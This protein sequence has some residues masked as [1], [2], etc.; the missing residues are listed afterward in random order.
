MSPND[1]YL[2]AFENP[3]R[4]R[5]TLDIRET[6]IHIETFDLSEIDNLREDILRQNKT[7]PF[8]ISADE[9]Y[10]ALAYPLTLMSNDQMATQFSQEGLGLKTYQSDLFN[11]WLNTEW[12]DGENNIEIEVR[13]PKYKMRIIS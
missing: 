5:E 4:F 12:I 10:K 9:P 7:T 3:V 11:N 8:M 2:I 1:L 6:P 13:T